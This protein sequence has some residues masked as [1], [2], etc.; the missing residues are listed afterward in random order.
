MSCG[1]DH[2]FSHEA[3]TTGK[4]ARALLSD[5]TFVLMSLASWC[6][7]CLLLFLAK[8]RRGGRRNGD[9]WGQAP[10]RGAQDR[11]ATAT[12][13]D[14][15]AMTN[16]CEAPQ[17]RG[18]HNEIER[19]QSAAANMPQ[20]AA[21][22][23]RSSARPASPGHTASAA[24]TAS[25][26]P[27]AQLSFGH[28]A[29]ALLQATRTRSYERMMANT[30]EAPPTPGVPPRSRSSARPGHTASAATTAR[31]SFDRS[32]PALLQT[33]ATSSYE[34]MMA[35]TREAPP[36]P[37]VPPRSR[38]S[39]RP[40]H[41]AS[42]TTTGAV[43][44][45]HTNSAPALLQASTT[46]SS[47]RMM[48]NTREAPPTPGALAR[49]S[50]VGQLERRS[51]LRLKDLVAERPGTPLGVGDPPRKRKTSKME[52]GLSSSSKFYA[53]VERSQRRHIESR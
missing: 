33:S 26:S 22:R 30:R 53:Y 51:F 35:N 50:R 38:S 12:A 14:R 45:S 42:A 10:R 20:T 36:T 13:F 7:L 4:I 39:A 31:V 17:T 40:G 47:E 19:R 32:A 9:Q 21:P 41:T 5:G 46:R 6:L 15:G 48:A 2:A 52:G 16:T 27:S 43:S 25:A 8:P 29:P 24:P 34:R 44:W 49:D 11:R 18:V 28:S 3:L 1:A 37:G 23:S